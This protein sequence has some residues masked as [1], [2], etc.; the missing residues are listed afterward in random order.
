ML[1]AAAKLCLT[2]MIT[3]EYRT[4]KNPVPQYESNHAE[5]DLHNYIKKRMSKV[6]VVQTKK[7][8][9]TGKD[10]STIFIHVF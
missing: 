10:P 7:G 4:H 9:A 2:G 6:K 1:R 8:L 3:N 5:L